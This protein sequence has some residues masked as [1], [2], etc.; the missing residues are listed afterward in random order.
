[1]IHWKCARG[2]VILAAAAVLAGGCAA[3]TARTPSISGGELSG[4]L[5]LAWDDGY[6]FVAYPIKGSE[7]T[8]KLPK[9]H[10]LAGLIGEIKPGLMFT[11]GGSIPRTFWSFDGL[12]PWEYG[13]AFI[14]HDWIF[15][16]HYCD[17]NDYPVRLDEAN[18]ILLDAMI[19]LDRQLREKGGKR[20]HN[21]EEVRQLIDAAVTKFSKN[22][23]ENGKCP[24][25]PDDLYKVVYETQTRRS[26][27]T[28]AGRSTIVESTKRVPRTVPRY[29]ELFVVSAD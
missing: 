18:D 12:S 24:K 25:T 27:R 19:L 14:L 10:R 26:V 4:K 29:R 13:P 7:L 11:D 3:L 5:A 6:Q 17:K 2:V 23:W 28:V 21:T 8:Y 20:P 1:M 22:A 15:S 9:G 16:R